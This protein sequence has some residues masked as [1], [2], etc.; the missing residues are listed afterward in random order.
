VVWV[1]TAKDI[2]AVLQLAEVILHSAQ[3]VVGVQLVQADRVLWMELA[4]VVA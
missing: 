1:L 2:Q 4:D 3:A